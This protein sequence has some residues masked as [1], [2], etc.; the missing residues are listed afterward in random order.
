[1]RPFQT[2]PDDVVVSYPVSA[3]TRPEIKAR[4]GERVWWY[5]SNAEDELYFQ[6]FDLNNIARD[7][8]LL[9]HNQTCDTLH[10]VRKEDFFSKHYAAT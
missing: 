10:V 3:H 2:T 4:F 9:V 1:M 6:G 5:D 8:D 7:G